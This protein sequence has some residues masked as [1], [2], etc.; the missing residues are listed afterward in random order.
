MVPRRINPARLRTVHLITETDTFDKKGLIYDRDRAALQPNVVC[1]D[2]D[3]SIIFEINEVGLKGDSIDP[4]RKLGVVWGDSVVFGS[5]R[6]WPCLLDRLAPGYQFLNGGLDG[7]HYDNILRR[8]SEFNRDHLVAL[9]LLM[10]GWHPLIPPQLEFRHRR[11]PRVFGQRKPTIVRSPASGNENIRSDL[12]TFLQHTPNTVVLTMPTALNPCIIDRD[13][14]SYLVDGGDESGFRFLGGIPYQ[15]EAQR[16]GCEHILERNDITR[17]V[18]A[19][20]GIRIID[21]FAALHNSPSRFP[22]EFCRHIAPAP[23]Q[24]F[25]TGEHHISERQRVAPMTTA[26]QGRAECSLYEIFETPLKG[27]PCS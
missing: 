13:L 21:V 22:R 19:R 24:L 14:S 16:L 5:G 27:I 8:A 15:V 4:H 18:C 11:T 12:T 17:E 20:L 1:I 2:R 26:A 3:G 23:P 6:G 25:L 9:N 7:D 10:L